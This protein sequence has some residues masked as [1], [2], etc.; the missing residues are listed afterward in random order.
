MALRK[1]AAPECSST[2]QAQIALCGK[3]P[4]P[5]RNLYG[6]TARPFNCEMFV[7]NVKK[8]LTVHQLYISDQ[9]TAVWAHDTTMFNSQCNI[10]LIR[11]SH[12]TFFVF[13]QPIFSYSFIPV[14]PRGNDWITIGWS[15]PARMVLCV[16]M[17]NVMM[18]AMVVL[19]P[20]G[21][22]LCPEEASVS[23]W[24]LLCTYTQS[25]SAWA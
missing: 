10:C 9:L 18:V 8:Q 3:N 17:P 2:I 16:V 14:S 12:V 1:V 5:P 15:S 6:F 4:S 25:G 20:H 19:C 23:V 11:T 7:K 21:A 22:M 24:Y 13:R